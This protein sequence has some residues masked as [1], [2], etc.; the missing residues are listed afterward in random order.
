MKRS[1][2]KE[3]ISPS[4]AQQSHSTTAQHIQVPTAKLL[5]V[6]GDFPK[7][8]KE[9]LEQ[10]G[11]RLHQ[12]QTAFRAFV[13]LEQKVNDAERLHATPFAMH[14]LPVAILCGTSLPDGDGWDLIGKIRELP[15]CSEIPT[16]LLHDE[17][18]DRLLWERAIQTGID[19]LY[20]PT[21][22]AFQIH[23]RISFL[24][25]FKPTFESRPIT[26]GKPNVSP[27]PIWKRTM[28][29]VLASLGLLLLGPFILGMAI[30]HR[31]RSRGPLFE[32]LVKVGRGYELIH[33]WQFHGKN[34][35]RST[36]RLWTSHFSDA[37]MLWNVFRGDMSIVGNRPLSMDEAETLTTDDWAGRFLAPAG[38]TGMWQLKRQQSPEAPTE[39]RAHLDTTY[40]QRMSL[41]TDL[42]LILKTLPLVF[43]RK[44]GGKSGVSDE[45]RAV[46]KS[47]SE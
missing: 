4:Y 38:I 25:T 40:S 1:I 45:L 32:S 19:D 8:L 15:E 42:G 28:D 23:S 10:Q 9:D 26:S 20:G 44:R 17:P 5:L 27:L 3:P 35:T 11:Y 37:P 31:G 7:T 18:I 46:Q 16:I 43:S 34:S 13:W 47:Y 2:S 29:L 22:N 14:P 36:S 30:I 41:R 24:V 12:T 6:I 39:V 21:V 33:C